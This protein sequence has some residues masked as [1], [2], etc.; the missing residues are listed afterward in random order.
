MRRR[1]RSAT[2]PLHR[3]SLPQVA[4][5]G[6]LVALAYWLA[7]RLRFDGPAGAPSHYEDLFDATFIPVVIGSIVIFAA[8][9]LYGK[10]WRYVTQRDY[11]S[12]VQAVVAA[13]LALLLYIVLVKPVTRT[14]G[15][16]E[17][18][19]TLPSG[20]LALHGLLMLTFVGGAR[21]IAR[22]VY[23]RPLRGFR[24]SKDAR[25]LLI[26]GAGDGGRLVLR[27]ILRNPELRLK[28]VGFVDDDPLKRRLRI[29]GV[30]V[31]GTTQEL[32]RI[33]DEVEPDEVTI[34]IPS[35]PGTLRA[36]VVRCCRERGIPVRTLP[37]VFELLQSGA[38][39][40]RQVRDVQIE[41]IL[42][43]EPVLMELNRV[44]AYLSS[45]VV[46]VTG[47]GGSIGKELSRQIARVVPRRLILLDHAEDNLFQ[48][49]R[50]LED[51]RHVHPS[52]LDVVLADCKEEERM[53]EVFDL[54]RPTVVF[55][56]AAYKHVGLMESN[57]VEAVRN[58]AIATRL[59]ARISGQT[60][61]KTFVLVSTDKA[62]DPSTVMGASKALAEFALE[63]EQARFP[64]SRFCAVRFGNVL[65]SSGSVVPIFRR[66][67]ALG[68]P[69]TVTDERMTRYFMTIPEAV[70]LIIRAGGLGKGG[71]GGE[72][73]VLEMG[74]PVR[75]LDLARTMIELSGLEPDRDIAVEIVG[76][77]P[78]EK[79][80][81][82]L[83]NPYERPQP[84]P[85]EK[86]LR[87][88]RS[89]R[90]PQVVDEM[91]DQ[92]GLLVLEGD[93]AGLAAKVSE[94]SAILEAAT[95]RISPAEPE[96]AAVISALPRS[97]SDGAHP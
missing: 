11:S 28:P 80:H 26:V 90:A 93:A 40:V 56:A 78:G 45:E 18:A 43:R 66:Q 58:N 61:V 67:I 49:Q 20:V 48:I 91:F 60:K 69:V 7:Y 95:T 79:L 84:T 88:E 37:T 75:I 64:Q 41:D 19:V 74:E 82:E 65:G 9:G 12:I 27:E 5:D 92:I 39:A 83:F 51:D 24:V 47:A 71:A 59:M 94:L 35:A 62:V 23:E 36:N 3:H 1:I 53:R 97:P 68:G 73:Y 38:T 81:E 42:G 17:T 54:Y 44:G 34:A 10:W 21:F 76:R 85:A 46:L 13:A 2:I 72:I 32:G 86:I 15:I 4:V 57:P 77:R 96:A 14:T 6:V 8:F 63:A 33:L 52:T 55:H 87:A 16:G 22:T 89:P 29:D 25:G 30:R 31:L 50:E 70:Q